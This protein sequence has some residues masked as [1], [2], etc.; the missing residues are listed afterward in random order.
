MPPSVR[1]P[2]IIRVGGKASWKNQTPHVTVRTRVAFAERGH[3]AGLKPAEREVLK[4]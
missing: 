2:P 3:L 4:C 1:R